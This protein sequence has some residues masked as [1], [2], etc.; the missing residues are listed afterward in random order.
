[1]PNHKSAQKRSRQSLKRKAV[2]RSML[3]NIKKNTQEFK[4]ILNSSKKSSTRS[5]SL[6]KTL[7]LLNS[8]LSR[9]VKKGLVKK[10][11][12]SRKLSSFSKQI[13]KI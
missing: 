12:V 3:N 8:S 5:E 10:Q 9:A 2:N 4:S 11:Y 13:K 7:G 6:I 1:M